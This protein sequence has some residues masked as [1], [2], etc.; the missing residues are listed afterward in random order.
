MPTDEQMARLHLS[1]KSHGKPWVDDRRVRIGMI[2]VNR[3]GPRWRNA[4]RNHGLQIGRPLQ[5]PTPT[6]RSAPVTL[7]MPQIS[8]DPL[9]VW[10]N[11][12]AAFLCNI[13]ARCILSRPN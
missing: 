5:R 8:A 4:L 10:N 6:D 3:N 11:L 1:P 13:N 12:S 9:A 2:I 7:V